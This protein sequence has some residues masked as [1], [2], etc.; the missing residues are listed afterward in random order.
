[1]RRC[2]RGCLIC[3]LTVASINFTLLFLHFRSEPNCSV[4]LAK[5]VRFNSGSQRDKERA[6]RTPLLQRI[7][8]LFSDAVRSNPERC[9]SIAGASALHNRSSLP[10][11]MTITE[12][13]DKAQTSLPLCNVTCSTVLHSGFFLRK[14]RRSEQASKNLYDHSCFI[15]KASYHLSPSCV[16]KVP[17]IF[18]PDLYTWT[19]LDAQLG[20]CAL[21]PLSPMQAIATWHKRSPRV[22]RTLVEHG[23]N[24]LTSAKTSMTTVLFVGDSFL[25]QVFEAIICRWRHQITGGFV[26]VGFEN[27][28]GA[29][30][31]AGCLERIIRSNGTCHGY[32]K[33]QYSRQYSNEYRQILVQHT[34]YCSDAVSCFEFGSTTRFCF[35]YCFATLKEHIKLV[36]ESGPRGPDNKVG[37]I[38][39]L[40]TTNNANLCGIGGAGGI[41]ADQA[42]KDLLSNALKA[43]LPKWKMPRLIVLENLRSSIMKHQLIRDMRSHSLSSGNHRTMAHF[44]EK[45][46]L[47]GARSEGNCD[48]PDQHFAMPGLPDA[49]GMRIL[50]MIATADTDPYAESIEWQDEE[51]KETESIGSDTFSTTMSLEAATEKQFDHGHS[52]IL[53]DESGQLIDMPKQD[54]SRKVKQTKGPPGDCGAYLRVISKHDNRHKKRG[55]NTRFKNEYYPSTKTGRALW[56]LRYSGAETELKQMEQNRILQVFEIINYI[57][58]LI[59]SFMSPGL[60][61]PGRQLWSGVKA[62]A[63]CPVY[64]LLG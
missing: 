38:D 56:T 43:A 48:D 36:A 2:W 61:D 19:L 13:L 58:M 52:A 26:T 25:R 17:P 32:F 44:L 53:L 47:L 29:L 63:E 28:P 31:R 15:L 6:R 9:T 21:T 54:R 55:G 1:M 57:S 39:I 33:K 14:R 50:A 11:P 42:A 3:F 5:K 60:L 30:K 22:F 46:H 49:E 41:G 34:P 23:K 59:Q 45:R 24:D 7:A 37:G 27:L 4:K 64:F 18:R 40:V 12:E 16:A 51:L 10:D 62:F 20:E 35:I 8:P